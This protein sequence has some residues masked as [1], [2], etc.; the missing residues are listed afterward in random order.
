V[1]NF[2]DRYGPWALVAGASAGLGA[3]FAHALAARGLNLVLVARRAEALES[4]AASLGQVQ[5]R[6]VVADLATEDGLAS[7]TSACAGLPIG[8]VVCNAAYSPIGAFVD[9][10]TDDAL[11]ALYLNARAPMLLAHHFL[12]AM[13]ARGTGGLV[14]MSS[15]SGL[16][17]SPPI[18]VYAATKAFGAI[19]AEGLWAELRGTGVDVVAALAG[20]IETPGLA[21]SKPKRA[22]GT[23]APERVAEAA[24]RALGHGPR[25]VPGLTMKLSAALMSRLPRR[26]AITIISRASR[27]LTPA[28]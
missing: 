25:V 21:A 5:T 11:Q 13:V 3:A 24:L 23:L 10:P 16:Q 17:G 26:T 20:A 28:G 22:P 18:S 14:I 7:V 15:L 2:A 4:V 6:R 12:P 27:D 8:L 1:R 9:L 19:L